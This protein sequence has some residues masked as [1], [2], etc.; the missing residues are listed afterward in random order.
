[1]SP[2]H[3]FEQQSLFSLQSLPSMAQVAFSE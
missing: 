2:L 3:T 1:V